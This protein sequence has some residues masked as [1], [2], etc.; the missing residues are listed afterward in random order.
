MST[1]NICFH[2]E[3]RKISILLDQKKHLIKSCDIH[4][5]M[6]KKDLNTTKNVQADLILPYF[7]MPPKSYS[8]SMTPMKNRK[9]LQSFYF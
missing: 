1:Y 6:Y 8:H 3:I 7:Q 5:L 4:V 2:G 9:L